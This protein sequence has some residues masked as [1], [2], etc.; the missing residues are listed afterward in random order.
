MMMQDYVK[1][2]FAKGECAIGRFWGQTHVYVPPSIAA[3]VC[4]SRLEALAAQ[5]FSQKR[6][7]RHQCS[8]VYRDEELCLLDLPSVLDPG[9]KGHPEWDLPQKLVQLI[10]KDAQERQDLEDTIYDAFQK[11]AHEEITKA[12]SKYIKLISDDDSK[13]HVGD[14]VLSWQNLSEEVR[15]KTTLGM[16]YLKA[17]IEG[18]EEKYKE[19]H[20]S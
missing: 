2:A 14:R 9:G 15:N 13:L 18:I 19:R 3:Y 8:D 10:L 6:L 11:S 1:E 12:F 20:T 16:N 4:N 5:V 17:T 7:D